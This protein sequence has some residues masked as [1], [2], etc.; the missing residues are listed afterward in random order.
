MP[1]P[2]AASPDSSS[3]SIGIQP[4]AIE[5]ASRTAAGSS[6]P[7]FDGL[8]IWAVA[9]ILVCAYIALG[10]LK[11]R[12]WQLDIFQQAWTQKI[13]SRRVL[14]IWSY[15]FDHLPKV[16]SEWLLKA[17]FGGALFVIVVGT[18]IGM[19]LILD[20]SETESTSQET[21]LPGHETTTSEGIPDHGLDRTPG[22]Q[23]PASGDV[24]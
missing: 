23:P 6:R 24:R 14:H 5:P 17:A 13:E 4:V 8:V 7:R 20:H 11:A 1:T 18:V 2:Q 15:Q 22:V 21:Y 19:W 3:Q 9:S 10:S 16:S 12:F